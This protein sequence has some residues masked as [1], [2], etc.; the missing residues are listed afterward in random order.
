V[1]HV[2]IL[3]TR[4]I[5][6]AHGGFETFAEHLALYLVGRDWRV[7]VYCQEEGAAAP[8]ED[9]W[10]GVRLVHIPVARQGAAGTIVF[11]WRASRHAAREPGV[12]LL[13]GY[14][15]G[16][17]NVVLKL[18]RRPVITNMDGI[19]WRRDKWG[20]AARAW[21]YLNEHAA[22][23]TSDQLVADHPEI[24][25]HLAR[26]TRA[27]KIV[28]IPYGAEDAAGADATPLSSLALE[29]Q[30]YA[31]VV[32]RP[33]P[34]NSLLEI[35]SGFAQA[36][37][38]YKLVVLGDFSPQTN[39]YHRKVLSQASDATV[40]PGAI[41]DQAVVGALR[42]HCA[43]Y[44]HGHRV[45]GTNPSLVEALGARCAVIAHDNPF[46]RWV[47]G[48]AA[49]YFSGAASLAGVLEEV[50]GSSTKREAMGIAAYQ[51]FSASFTWPAVLAEYE[52]VLDT[53]V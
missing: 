35:V 39:R 46:N 40:F 22:S 50:L 51:R 30:R 21:F 14:N 23:I 16:V 3:G 32:A 45:G 19:E 42:R 2:S 29:P 1:K 36:K 31:L 28:M 25:R 13:L 34:E 41:F 48:E 5:P 10:K 49:C 43:V 8:W 38:G 9:D 24:Q 47:A 12:K 4:G 37:T 53:W 7:T 18:A 11:D 15:T 44:I 26:H 52:T 6:A 20:M 33:E 27:R 17:F